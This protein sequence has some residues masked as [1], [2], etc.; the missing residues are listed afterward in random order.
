MSHT[1]TLLADHHGFTGPKVM[2]HEYYV[3]A[4]INVTKYTSDLTLTGDFVAADN[5]FTLTTADASDFS[6]LAI[7]GSYTITN[8]ADAG[9][10][11]TV[12]IEALSGSGG[13][14]SV[15]TFSAVSADHSADAITLSP[16]EHYLPARAFG[17]SSISCFWITG[18]EDLL[19]RYTIKTTDA[20]AYLDAKTLE[21]MILVG[22]TGAELA[23]EAVTGDCIR[24]RVFGQL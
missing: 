22:S 3:D 21:L 4:A 1:I 24:V 11:A 2:G 19:N 5:T 23:D 12:T 6:E 9:N 15:I 17:L 18:Q 20:G 10:N 7:G 16:A 13:T 14:G 8:A